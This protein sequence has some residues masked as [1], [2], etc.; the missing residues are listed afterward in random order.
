LE[1]RL[2]LNINSSKKKKAICTSTL[3]NTLKTHG[4]FIIEKLFIAKVNKRET[5]A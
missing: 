1:I 2:F 5:Q 4:L 3:K